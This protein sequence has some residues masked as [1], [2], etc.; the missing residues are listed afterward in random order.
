MSKRVI[1]F[2]STCFLLLLSDRKQ[3]W[4]DGGSD[5]GRQISSSSVTTED[6]TLLPEDRIP[7]QVPRMKDKADQPVFTMQLK[8]R[9]VSGSL[10]SKN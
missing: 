10:F 2:S 7:W 1:G 5:P 8:T 3:D 9:V 6:T 4:I